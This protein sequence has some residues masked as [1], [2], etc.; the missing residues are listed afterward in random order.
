MVCIHAL[1]SLIGGAVTK[2][3]RFQHC[4]QTSSTLAAFVSPEDVGGGRDV[5]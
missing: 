1:I 2:G 3:R 4:G 5:L